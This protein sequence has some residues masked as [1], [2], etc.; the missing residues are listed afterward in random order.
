ML[1]PTEI[2]CPCCGGSIF[3]NT[4]KLIQGESFACSNESCK[5]AI[6]IS[7]SSTPIVRNA[8]EQLDELSQAMA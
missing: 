6:A 5:A 7:S 4:E 8:L 3:I 2:N 1:K